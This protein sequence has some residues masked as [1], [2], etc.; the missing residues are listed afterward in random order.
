MPIN[1]GVRP[2]LWFWAIGVVLLLWGLIGCFAAYTQITTGPEA[3]GDPANAE[4]NRQLYA[5]LPAWFNW[6]YA[7]AVGSAAVGA[8]ALALRRAVARPIFI[9]SAIAVVIQFGYSFL[10]TD[11]IAHKG[12]AMTVPFP[13]F[14]LAVAVFSVWFAG[15]S[16]RRGWLS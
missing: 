8:L 16:Q 10:A 11:L 5:S 15:L 14:I 9:L 12:V 3:W 7:L 6:V 1:S 13:L 2:P 4:Y